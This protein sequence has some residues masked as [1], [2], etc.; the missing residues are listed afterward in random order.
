MTA[1][2]LGPEVVKAEI[3]DANWNWMCV[4]I[5][6]VSN[7]GQCNSGDCC[8]NCFYQPNN[9]QPTGKEDYYYCEGSSSATGTSYVKKKDYKCTGTSS[10]STYVNTTVDTC[11]TCEYCTNYDST[12]NSYSS[13]TVCESNADVEYDCDGSACGADVIKRYRD[14]Y[15]NGSS[16][17]SYGSWKSWQT[18]DN[19]SS[20]EVCTVGDSSC[21]SAQSHAS[22]QCSGD[23]IYYYDAC[24]SK[25]DKK[26]DCGDS[27]YTGNNYCHDND[28]YRNYVTRGCSGNSCTANTTKEKQD[29]CE[30]GCSNNECNPKPDDP[31]CTSG[32]CCNVSAKT[33]RPDSYICN[34]EL[35][36][37]FRCETNECGADAQSRVKVQYCSGNSNECNGDEEW[38]EW[39][40]IEDCDTDDACNSGEGFARCVKCPEG[41]DDNS[42]ECNKPECTEGECCKTLLG[43]VAGSD[44]RC[45]AKRSEDYE[46]YRCNGGETCGGTLEVRHHEYYCDGVNKYCPSTAIP[47]AWETVEVCTLTKRCDEDSETCVS[48]SA[49]ED[50]EV[51]GD[52]NT[53]NETDGDTSIDNGGGKATVNGS[54]CNSGLVINGNAGLLFGAFVILAGFAVY[55]VRRK[56]GIFVD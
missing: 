21:N 36:E 12:C 5:W 13:S 49:C 26:Q 42:G 38:L 48:D 17:S 29:D 43:K 46:E 20:S 19:C 40:I 23:D 11:G 52:D 33:F 10:S 35:E 44:E 15:C 56:L 14:K 37:E 22:Y 32:I 47:S 41:C 1:P 54:G 53:G 18:A 9:Y 51:D 4:K 39:E 8:H 6:K 34:D 7:G 24:G 16:C 28:V 30:Y 50:I 55:R 45:P 27:G 25:E 31:D 3:Y 2:C